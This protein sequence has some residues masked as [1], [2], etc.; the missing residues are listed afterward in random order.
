MFTASFYFLGLA[1]SILAASYCLCRARRARRCVEVEL[2]TLRVASVCLPTGRRAA[3]EDPT[4]AIFHALAWDEKTKCSDTKAM[5]RRW[6]DRC[7][8]KALTTQQS[9]YS[10]ARTLTLCAAL[11]LIGVL[12]EA[13]FDQPITLRTVLAGFRRPETPTS[14]FE[15]LDN[16]SAASVQEILPPVK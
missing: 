10:W 15:R 14:Q 8:E 4:D 6:Y 12:L 11:C 1:A 2:E 16:S 9:A 7:Q 3:A 13:E 5:W